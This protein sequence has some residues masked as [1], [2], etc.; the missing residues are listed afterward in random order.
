MSPPHVSSRVR[1]QRDTLRLIASGSGRRKTS[2]ARVRL[3]PFPASALAAAPDADGSAHAQPSMPPVTV[4]GLPAIVYF[5][6]SAN[7]VGSAL[8]PLLATDTVSHFSVDATVR[9]G[10]ATGQSGAIRLAVARALDALRPDL[11][12][13][14]KHGG[15]PAAAGAPSGAAAVRFNLLTRDARVVERKKPGKP[16]ARKSF[17]WVKR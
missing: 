14:L 12:T 13:A 6:S 7:R 11:H 16:K 5:N 2:T 1:G 17:Q 3:T 4:N 8:L 15:R 9:G 10:G